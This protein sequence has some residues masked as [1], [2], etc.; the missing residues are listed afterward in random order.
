MAKAPRRAAAVLLAVLGITLAGCGTTI[1]HILAE[2]GRYADRDVT[3]SGDVVKSSSV[4]GRGAYMLDDGTGRL[5][6]VTK[7]GTPRQ[8]ARVQVSGR[9]RD[10]VNLGGVLD[11]PPEVG[12]G[13]V[14]VEKSHKA[15]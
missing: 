4:L 15:K 3:L 12:S 2:P 9:V 13:L 8:G 10:V 5:W 7:T 11:L 14:M 1:N 6:V